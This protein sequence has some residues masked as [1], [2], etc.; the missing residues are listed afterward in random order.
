MS[1]T[2]RVVAAPT[3]EKGAAVSVAS[4]AVR[5]DHVLVRHADWRGS[6]RSLWVHGVEETR[7]PFDEPCA[8]AFAGEGRLLVADGSRLV[9]CGP[10]GEDAQV[11]ATLEGPPQ[12]LWVGPGC[13][14]LVAFGPQLALWKSGHD[15]PPTWRSKLGTM[16]RARVIADGASVWLSG[17]DLVLTR[18]S[19]A[20]GTVEERLV[21]PARDHMTTPF[22]LASDGT[23]F[24]HD[25]DWQLAVRD[26]GPGHAVLASVAGAGADLIDIGCDPTGRYVVTCAHHH[27]NRQYG[28]GVL[29]YE[30]R[31][32]T[33]VPVAFDP[34]ERG[35]HAV[36]TTDGRVTIA[37]LDGALRRYPSP[38]AETERDAA[39]ALS[40]LPRR[41]PYDDLLWHPHLVSV[42]L[43]T[44]GPVTRE[45]RPLYYDSDHSETGAS[46][47]ALEDTLARTR[48]GAAAARVARE[49]GVTG[50]MVPFLVYKCSYPAAPG[51]VPGG[52]H[53][54]GY[55]LGSFVYDLD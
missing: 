49:L 53:G 46:Q 14:A 7:L 16:T 30:R 18:V 6:D 5:G 36:V 19:V 45:G 42:W 54:G 22:A 37:T 40:A 3:N 39:T 8:A 1:W 43:N 41:E 44:D 27:T 50:P 24:T 9:G 17:E 34:F 33:L 2:P 38:D 31:D 52:H 35:L 32:A 48:F 10:S 13:E 26:A 25:H 20:D 11:Q 21:L 15:G 51:P 55:Y 4:L 29:L 47:P 28:G 12:E 23:L